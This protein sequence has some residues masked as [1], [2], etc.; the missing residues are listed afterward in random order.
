M[1]HDSFRI[2]M[3]GTDGRR[4]EVPRI[5]V[6]STATKYGVLLP[7]ISSLSFPCVRVSLLLDVQTR[8]ATHVQE[9]LIRARL[10]QRP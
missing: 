8:R 10:Q 5:K 3:P 4:Y 9:R 6:F 2:V 7:V 1:T